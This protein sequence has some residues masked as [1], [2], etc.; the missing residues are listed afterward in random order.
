MFNYTSSIDYEVFSKFLWRVFEKNRF[1][2]WN[3]PLFYP[4]NEFF[5]KNV[6]FFQIN[7]ILPYTI[8]FLY[9]RRILWWVLDPCTIFSRYFGIFSIFSIIISPPK[10]ALFL[11]QMGSSSTSLDRSRR[12]AFIGGCFRSVRFFCDFLRFFKK[13]R[14]WPKYLD[15]R[16]G[17][18]NT[19][20]CMCSIPLDRSHQYKLIGACFRSVR[21]FCYFIRFF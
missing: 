10:P 15:S 1:L 14:F 17:P 4:K 5:G 8:E 20:T 2:W 7:C 11:D 16:R 18:I 3:F 13:S 9:K 12:D 21:F 6:H 19:S